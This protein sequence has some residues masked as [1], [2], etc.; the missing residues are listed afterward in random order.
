MVIW[1]VSTDCTF[2]TKHNSPIWCFILTYV[3]N[4]HNYY[5]K[6]HIL[7]IQFDGRANCSKSCI[8][9]LLQNLPKTWFVPPWR[10]VGSNAKNKHCLQITPDGCSWLHITLSLS[11]RWQHVFNLKLLNCQLAAINC[12]MFYCFVNKVLVLEWFQYSYLFF[13]VRQLVQEQ[14]NHCS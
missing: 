4:F 1:K 3:Y 12:L 11:T 8:F 6:N 14:L 9:S 5:V 2:L 13:L 10:L 7:K